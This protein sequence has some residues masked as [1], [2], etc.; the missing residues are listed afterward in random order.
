MELGLAFSK[1]VGTCYKYNGRRILPLLRPKLPKL[2]RLL[3][4]ITGTGSGKLFRIRPGEKF[5]ITTQLPT[6]QGVR[7]LFASLLFSVFCSL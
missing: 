7:L 3:S 4:K 5:R 6:Y 1:E 2:F